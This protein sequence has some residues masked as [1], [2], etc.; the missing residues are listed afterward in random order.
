M[1]LNSIQ[2]A[3]YVTTWRDPQVSLFFIFVLQFFLRY[4]Y[5]DVVL[6]VPLKLF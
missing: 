6:K 5:F 1:I 2:R 4:M 3:D